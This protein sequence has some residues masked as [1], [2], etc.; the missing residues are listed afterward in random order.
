MVEPTEAR[1][2]DGDH[3]YEQPADITLNAGPGWV[4]GL[5]ERHLR[6]RARCFFRE[7]YV[8]LY[9][10]LLLKILTCCASQ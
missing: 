1:V 10:R 8:P 2:G 5:G 6:F 7:S 3:K 9:F 4:I